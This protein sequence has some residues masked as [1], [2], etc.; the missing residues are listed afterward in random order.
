MHSAKAALRAE[1]YKVSSLSG[2]NLIILNINTIQLDA[3]RA[4]GPPEGAYHPHQQT[5][6]LLHDNTPVLSS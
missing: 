5:T 2:I 4:V 6:T 1:I 3:C